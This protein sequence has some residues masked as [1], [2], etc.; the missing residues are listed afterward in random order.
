MGA[1]VSELVDLTQDER[2]GLAE[3]VF[4]RPGEFAALAATPQT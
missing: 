1:H 3:P 2:S 4:A